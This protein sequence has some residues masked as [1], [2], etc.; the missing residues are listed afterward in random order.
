MFRKQGALILSYVGDLLVNAES[1]DILCKIKRKLAQ[2]LPA[3]EL[4]EAVDYSGIK[5]IRGD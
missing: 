4:G 1:C 3:N 2:L 5:I